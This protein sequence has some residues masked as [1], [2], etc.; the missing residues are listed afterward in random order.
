[1]RLRPSP[2]P[3]R[4]RKQARTRAHNR[5]RIWPC[6]TL[7]VLAVCRARILR[8]T[9]TDPGL[10]ESDRLILGQAL[11]FD[12][13]GKLAEAEGMGLVRAHKIHAGLGG[14]LI[15]KPH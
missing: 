2:F 7:T 1:M 3:R 11:R 13:L 15:F 5:W 4:T 12:T 8:K 14:D 6:N 9:S 10:P